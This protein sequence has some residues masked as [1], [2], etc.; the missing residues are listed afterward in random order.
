MI[1]AK[2]LSKEFVLKYIAGLLVVFCTYAG[3]GPEHLVGWLLPIMPATQIIT[4]SLFMAVALTVSCL[5]AY[6]I[7]V[8]KRTRQATPAHV[9]LPYDTPVTDAVNYIIAG[10]WHDRLN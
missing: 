7:Y 8:E 3:F 9:D 10:N 5:L 4:R 6:S 2:L 1:F